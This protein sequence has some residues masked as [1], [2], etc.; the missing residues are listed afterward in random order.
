MYRQRWATFI[1]LLTG[2]VCFGDENLENAEAAPRSRSSASS[3]DGFP[4]HSD[5]SSSS[6]SSSS[7][8]SSQ[9]LPVHDFDDRSL[10]DLFGEV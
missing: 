10:L 2:F 7:F 6:S 9:V 1:V 3:E 4:I 5:P 8:S